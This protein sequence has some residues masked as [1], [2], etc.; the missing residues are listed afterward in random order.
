LWATLLSSALIVG[1]MLYQSVKSL[2]R[3]PDE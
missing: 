2:V 1:A 3:P